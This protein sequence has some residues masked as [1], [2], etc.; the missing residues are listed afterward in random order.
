M[1]HEELHAA[2]HSGA[3][4]GASTIAEIQ[5][6]DLERVIIDAEARMHA[7]AAR[8]AEVWEGAGGDAARIGLHSL[9]SWVL[10]ATTDAQTTLAALAGQRASAGELRTLMPPPNT[11]EVAA[12]DAEVAAHPGDAER[13][14]AL[15]D[16]RAAAAEDARRVMEQYHWV[17]VETRRIIDFWT[18]PPT[19]LVEVALPGTGTTGNPARDGLP[20]LGAGP[21]VSNTSSGAGA[22]PGGGPPVGPVVAGLS[23]TGVGP[24]G[25]GTPGGAGSAPAGQTGTGGPGGG[26]GTGGAVGAGGAGGGAPVAGTGSGGAV[27]GAG[28]ATAGVPGSRAVEPSRGGPAGYGAAPVTGPGVG[29]ASPVSGRDALPP[30]AGGRGPRSGP[31]VGSWPGT[32]S[33]G[34][35]P[36]A[37]PG[38]GAA[39][40]WRDVV[41]GL[42][43]GGP[44]GTGG[45]AEP[46][47]APRAGGMAR[48]E[49]RP[50]GA[51]PVADAGR[52]GTAHGFYPPMGG[53]TAGGQGESRK[54]AP[55]LVDD[56]GVFDVDV[57]CTDPVIGAVGP[58]ADGT[59]RR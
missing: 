58:A 17:S 7:A 37:P 1:T 16:A 52:G 5:W 47:A 46:P 38:G 25:G 39:P 40:T 29:G 55:F 43:G 44:G 12:A 19:V 18:T 34:A 28:P 35:F 8:T 9:N 49:A 30:G 48:P 24:E 14:W 42:R 51:P 23:P 27:V 26:A 20:D 32:G 22:A 3:G 36:V 6:R 45:V 57:P 15:V 56:S 54:R 2:V 41:A 21:A 11:A 13:E 10:G 4:P 53:G 31:G 50:V 33:R 59:D